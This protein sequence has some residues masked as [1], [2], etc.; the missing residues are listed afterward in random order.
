MTDKEQ[1]L[2]KTAE[3]SAI[4]AFRIST[5]VGKIPALTDSKFGGM[6]YW[7]KTMDYPV[8]SRGEKMLLLAQINFA[9]L[10]ENDK[11]PKSGLLQFFVAPDDVYGAEFST[12]DIQ[13]DFRVIYHKS[14]DPAVTKESL[15]GLDLPA[16][17]QYGDIGFPIQR[18]MALSFEKTSI[19][20]GVTDYRYMD[21]VREAAQLLGAEVP[22]EKEPYRFLKNKEYEREARNVGHWLLGYP[23]F[24][25]CDPREGK[26]ALQRFD[27]MLLQI[28]SEYSNQNP[29]YEIMWG[30]AGVANF[31]ISGEALKRGDFSEIMYTWD[32]G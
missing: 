17:D 28:D 23:Y 27:T 22:Q 25:Q 29:D 10:P 21:K 32:C 6:P 31:F 4:E 30:D 3:I 2:E 12:P 11:F 26:E 9:E 18:E 24:T 5:V 14:T 16:G 19:S 7:D 13:K 20:I 15:S 8:S 1:I